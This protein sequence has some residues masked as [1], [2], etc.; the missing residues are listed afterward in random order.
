ML[1]FYIYIFV[2]IVEFYGEWEDVKE[3]MN[4]V[5]AIE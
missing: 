2:H 1:A 3:G 5:F 4:I